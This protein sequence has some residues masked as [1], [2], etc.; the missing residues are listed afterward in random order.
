MD[1]IDLN[2][3]DAS[4]VYCKLSASI[5]MSSYGYERTKVVRLQPHT[6]F[7]NRLGQVLYLKQHGV[8]EEDVLGPA[9]V[10]KPLLWRSI[11][12]QELVQVRSLDGL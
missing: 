8:L 11:Y 2:A 3:V 4:G 1:R 6:V 9:E 12:E 5:E 7:T 10:A